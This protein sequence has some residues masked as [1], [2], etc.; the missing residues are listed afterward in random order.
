MLWQFLDSASCLQEVV[1]RKVVPYDCWNR[2]QEGE[3]AHD[4]DFVESHDVEFLD[5]SVEGFGHSS[6]LGVARTEQ[7]DLDSFEYV[8]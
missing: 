1:L 7:Y 8:P 2:L 5:W 3:P 6:A 4:R